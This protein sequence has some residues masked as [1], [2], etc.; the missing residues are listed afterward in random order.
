MTALNYFSNPDD[1]LVIDDKEYQ[2]D[3]RM[4]TVI[5]FMYL[6]ADKSVPEY[7]KLKQGLLLMIDNELQELPLIDRVNVL[8]SLAEYINQGDDTGVIYD[9]KGNPIPQDIDEEVT[10]F[11]QDFDYIYSAFIQTYG[12]D[13]LESRDLDYR[14]YKALLRSLPENTHYREIIKLRTTDETKYKGA[15]RDKIKRAKMSVSLKKG[16]N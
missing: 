12:I 11:E 16:G 6:I 5:R 9:R 8:N 13:L 2:I 10:D 15:D 1:R 7:L 4:D 14:K 3:M